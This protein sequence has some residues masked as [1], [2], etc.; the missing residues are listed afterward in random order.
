[1]QSHWYVRSSTLRVNT[2]PCKMNFQCLHITNLVQFGLIVYLCNDKYQIHNRLSITSKLNN[3]QDG[4]QTVFS[5]NQPKINKTQNKPDF[6]TDLQ[7][8]N[9]SNISVSLSIDAKPST[10]NGKKIIYSRFFIL[11]PLLKAVFWSSQKS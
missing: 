6:E 11:W 7:N 4:H 9:T 5:E 3:S 10:P 2:D 8:L 1:M